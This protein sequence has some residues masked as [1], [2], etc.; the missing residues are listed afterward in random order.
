MA[1][2][3]DQDKSEPAT[4]YKL[5]K[6]REKGQVAKSTEMVSALVILA[7]MLCMSVGAWKAATQWFRWGH[8]LM[9][10]A[11]SMSLQTA[12]LWRLAADL[13]ACLLG[14]VLPIGGLVMVVAVLG[15]WVQAGPVFAPSLVAVDLDRINPIHSLKR[16]FSM[17]FVFELFRLVTL[18]D[19]VPS[20]RQ[21]GD[22][23]GVVVRERES[24]RDTGT[25]ALDAQR[26]GADSGMSSQREVEYQVGRRVEQVVSSPGAVRRIQLVA[27]IRQPLDQAQQEQ[28]RRVLSAAVGAH[29]E[30]GDVV[31]VQSVASLMSDPS[32]SVVAQAVDS[33]PGS[34]QASA[35]AASASPV[36]EGGRFDWVWRDAWLLLGCFVLLIL[37]WCLN[38]RRSLGATAP[39]RMSEADRSDALRQVEAWLQ[40]ADA[41]ARELGSAD[42]E[43]RS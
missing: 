41:T 37:A 28:W 10:Q 18:E 24:V 26:P 11:S 13:L 3:E 7:G 5:K 4:E 36:L 40:A 25:A 32:V 12:D 43:P 29:P 21:G 15:H 22:N 33:V 6:S 8:S 31:V 14:F 27:V 30:R 35:K 2:H 20:T 1:D 19:V 39:A 42:P 16:L 9:R 34:S 17:R 23:K 38:R